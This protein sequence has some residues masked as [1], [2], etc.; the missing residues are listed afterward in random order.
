M[1]RLQTDEKPRANTEP[2]EKLGTCEK[3]HHQ[4]EGSVTGFPA[5]KGGPRKEAATQRELTAKIFIERVSKC[6]PFAFTTSRD[7]S[8]ALAALAATEF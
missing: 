2:Q 4:E 3:G 7:I 6:K 5:K 8:F 1:R